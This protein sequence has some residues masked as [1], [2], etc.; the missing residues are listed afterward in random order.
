MGLFAS[1]CT[2]E[3]LLFKKE[4]TES[5]LVG[6]HTSGLPAFVFKSLRKKGIILPK[7]NIRVSYDEN[8]TIILY[9]Y[10]LERPNIMIC[11]INRFFL[12]AFLFLQKLKTDQRFQDFQNGSSVSKKM[13][14]KD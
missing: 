12:S 7:W 1:Y 9:T 5:K 2:N 8:M 6:L 11:I 4:R 10:L 13:P 3:N 14:G